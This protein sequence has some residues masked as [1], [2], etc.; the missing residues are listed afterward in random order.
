MTTDKELLDHVDSISKS[1]GNLYFA[2]HTRELKLNK[3]INRRGF[4]RR[5]KILY[6]EARKLKLNIIVGLVRQIE[7]EGELPVNEVP[8][9]T[10]IYQ[11]QVIPPNNRMKDDW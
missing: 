1:I 8:L 4:E 6:A 3:S 7:N 5:L 11:T 2:Y 10:G 9:T